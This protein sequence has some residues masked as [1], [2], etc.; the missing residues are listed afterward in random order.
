MDS[1][2]P[3]YHS[4]TIIQGF[5]TD[6]RDQKTGIALALYVVNPSSIP[7]GSPK[8]Y[9]SQELALS[10]TGCGPNT[11]KTEQ[12]WI[13]IL[14]GADWPSGQKASKDCMV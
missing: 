2:F 8:L 13:P 14:S 7:A 4:D 1:D 5:Q 12:T 3:F 10:T 11:N 6:S 9:Q